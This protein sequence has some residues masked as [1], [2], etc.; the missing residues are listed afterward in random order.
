MS[1]DYFQ[2][3][4]M[5]QRLVFEEAELKDAWHRAASEADPSKAEAIHGAYSVLRD[6]ARRIE[7]VLALHS[8]TT[9]SAEQPGARLFDL[10]FSV[11][12]ALK[13]ADAVVVQIEAAA[14]ALQRAGL[15]PR[16][17][18]SLD[19]LAEARTAVQSQRAARE[20]SLQELAARFPRLTDADWETLTSL[21]SDFSFLTKWAGEIQ[22]RETRLQEMLIGQMA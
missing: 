1:G 11:A 13:A 17:L 9:A 14:T 18:G 2:V 4:R 15:A 19:E 20:T 7:H 22:K 8:R 12:S 21:G 6:P 10:F 5:P 16:L 3:L